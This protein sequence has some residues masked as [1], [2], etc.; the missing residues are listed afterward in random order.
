MPLVGRV[1]GALSMI[2]TITSV[3][4]D[5]AAVKLMVAVDGLPPTTLVGFTVSAA[6]TGGGAVPKTLRIALR[7]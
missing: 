4:T 1:A 6:S 5:R 7:V 3:A 2:S